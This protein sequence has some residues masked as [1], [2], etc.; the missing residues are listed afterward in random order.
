MNLGAILNMAA[1]QARAESIRKEEE[2]RNRRIALEAYAEEARNRTRVAPPPL[3]PKNRPCF[4]RPW[5]DSEEEEGDFRSR[6]LLRRLMNFETVAFG[7]C[8]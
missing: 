3:P 7:S 6:Q 2:A 5:E 8:L 4:W 1:L